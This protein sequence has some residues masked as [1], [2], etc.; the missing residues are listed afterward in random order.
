MIQLLK[1]GLHY[2][3]TSYLCFASMLDCNSL[4]HY[5]AH[6]HLK[7]LKQTKIASRWSYYYSITLF[8]WMYRDLGFYFF[9]GF[10]RIVSCLKVQVTV[11]AFKWLLVD[12]WG[13]INKS[14]ACTEELRGP[15][16]W[17]MAV[18][19]DFCVLSV[20]RTIEASQYIFDFNRAGAT[21]MGSGSAHEY[22]C[23]LAY[24]NSN[25]TIWLFLPS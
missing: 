22:F 20:K 3:I 18:P 19:I 11:F 17:V 5:L 23:R 10:I 1:K 21:S 9:L 12:S 8:I 16:A 15:S 7:P 25:L 4:V 13:I 24:G 6:F 14:C 2:R